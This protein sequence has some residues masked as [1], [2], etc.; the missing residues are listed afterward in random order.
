MANNYVPCNL[1]FQEYSKFVE[2]TRIY[3]REPAL[4]YTGLGLADEAG[5]VA[6]NLKRMLRDDRGILTKARRKAILLE[7]GDSLWY[8]TALAEELDSSLEEIACMNKTKLLDR[9]ER[10]VL[11]GQGDNR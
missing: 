6:G 5:E 2:E 4:M 10:G 3:P 8:V 11:N 7:L 9:M 1:T